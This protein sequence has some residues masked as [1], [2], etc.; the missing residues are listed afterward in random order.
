MEPL[1]LDKIRRKLSKRRG[2][3]IP[4]KHGKR[5]LLIPR[6]AIDNKH[7]D[8]HFIVIMSG[9]GFYEF[10]PRDIPTFNEFKLVTAG[11]R[12][13]DAIA[14]YQLLCLVFLPDSV[15]PIPK[16]N[17]LALAYPATQADQTTNHENHGQ[18]TRKKQKG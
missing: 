12:Y 15:P 17:R 11:W 8:Q 1:D 14:V 7:A 3:D 18:T 10:H 4:T 2:V 13:A 5:V 9:A 6:S 16:Q